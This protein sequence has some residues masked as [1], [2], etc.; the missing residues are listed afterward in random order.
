MGSRSS[1]IDVADSR[2]DQQQ[3]N[4]LG[5]A[6]TAFLCVMLAYITHALVEGAVQPTFRDVVVG[7]VGFITA[8]LSTVY[9]FCYGTSSSNKKQQETIAVQAQTAA[10]AQ[11]ALAPIVAAATA[12]VKPD[13][14][15]Q[16]DWD[17]MSDA[18]KVIAAAK[19]DTA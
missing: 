17:R 10:S 19:K 3:L 12:P 6:L 4:W 15:S 2:L 5:T 11:A 1:G 13:A 16:Q 7:L 14:I 9:D 18:E 8:K